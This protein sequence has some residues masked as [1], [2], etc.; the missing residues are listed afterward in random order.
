MY[1]F[2]AK[3]EEKKITTTKIQCNENIEQEPR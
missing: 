1:F 2:R 3:G